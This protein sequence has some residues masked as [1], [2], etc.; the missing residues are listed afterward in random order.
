MHPCPLQWRCPCLWRDAC[1]DST[2]VLVRASL[3]GHVVSQDAANTSLSWSA[4]VRTHVLEPGLSCCGLLG[5]TILRCGGLS[6][7]LQEVWPPPSECQ[8]STPPAPDRDNRECL[9]RLPSVPWM[10]TAASSC[11][12]LS[13]GA[14]TEE[15]CPLSQVT[16]PK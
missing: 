2:R 7:A 10:R 11:L 14:A 16:F 3:I 1:P 8:A 6:C 12:S 13:P 9:Q 4:V 15:S 5:L